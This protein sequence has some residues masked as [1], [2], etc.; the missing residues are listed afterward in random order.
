MKK[1]SEFRNALSAKQALK[2]SFICS[3]ILSLAISSLIT[4]LAY[5][6]H[7]TSLIPFVIC[8]LGLFAMFCPIFYLLFDLHAKEKTEQCKTINQEFNLTTT[9]YTEV[10][11]NYEKALEKIDEAELLTAILTHSACRFFS[12]L[13][14]DEQIEVVIKDKD[15]NIIYTQTLHDFEY[16]ENH[17]TVK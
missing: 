15:E 17:F 7:L 1:F 14:E 4:L 2:L 13:T 10:R 5:G 8:L 3:F 16:F 11:Y 9:D 6:F 12:K